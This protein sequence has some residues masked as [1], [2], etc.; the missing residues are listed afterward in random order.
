M[1]VEKVTVDNFVRA[2]TNRM[3]AAL[4]ERAGG[5]NTWGHFREPTPLDAQ[6]VIRVNQD[7]LYS[8]AVVDI[9]RGA[10]VTLPDAGKRYL[11]LMVINQDHY[12]NHVI[13]HPGEHELTM[14]D[15]D[16]PFVLV[17]V[18]TLV[19][20]ADRSDVAAV[21]ALQDQLAVSA[22]SAQPFTGPDVDPASLTATRDTLLELARG[23]K[24][25]S[26][27]FGSREE[28]DPVRHLI[29]TAAGWGG[30]PEREAFYVNVDPSLPV[31]EYELTVKDVPVDA[32]WSISVYNADGYF[33]AN[34]RGKNSVNS[35]TAAPNLDGSTTV[36][37]GASDADAANYLPIMDGWNYLVRLYRPRPEILEGSWVFPAITTAGRDAA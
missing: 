13:H 33:V 2:E 11:S 10:T 27:C 3:F 12:I 6:T 5:V 16:T 34:T 29:G 31:G 9:S 36:R 24:G 14:E 22:I 4:A 19:D 1:S 35:I 15:F 28:V 21:N 26:G 37:F 7:T 20:P 8:W 25:F 30:L 23:I 18:R 32:F 17:A